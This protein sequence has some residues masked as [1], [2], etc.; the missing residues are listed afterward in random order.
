MQNS[1]KEN[2]KLYNLDQIKSINNSLSYL[3]RVMWRFAHK[4]LLASLKSKIIIQ[5][6]FR[7]YKPFLLRRLKNALN[8][9]RNYS[10]NIISDNNDNEIKNE[11]KEKSKMNEELNR[12]NYLLNEE[13]KKNEFLNNKVKE[14]ENFNNTENEK[15]KINEEINTSNNLLNE[16]IKKND[17]LNNKVKE[18]EKFINTEK[19]KNK[20]IIRELN[21]KIKEL[22]KVCNKDNIINLM[23]K[24]IR[25]DE[26]IRE[27]ESK[28]PIVL[29]KDE[30][31]MSVIFISTNHE[32]KQSII[33][34]NTDIFNKLVN[35]LYNK[36]PSYRKPDNFFIC[37]GKRVNEYETLEN[38]GIRDSSEIIL[39]KMYI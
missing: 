26:Q 30:K 16:E 24:I 32:I 6:I 37:N 25:K 31:L 2:L 12:L 14:L 1:N 19:E 8:I 39:S 35:I 22:E 4:D 21:D 7:I 38:N 11:E 33:C 15:S 13:K 17:S 28:F 9:W 36:F 29:S 23:E 18:L 34:K 20:E 27:L 3:Q 5:I 10:K